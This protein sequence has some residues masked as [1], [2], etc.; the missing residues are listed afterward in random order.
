MLYVDGEGSTVGGVVGFGQGVFLGEGGV[1]VLEVEADGEGAAVESCDDVGFA[2]DPAGVVGGGAGECGVEELLV[3]LTEAADV[4]D[5]GMVSGDGEFAEGESEGP[6]GIEIEGG[7]AEE[8]FLVG[9]AGEI[10]GD[11]HAGL[12]PLASTM[13][14]GWQGWQGA[15]PAEIF[16]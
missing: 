16:A 12:G 10:V 4:D 13:R 9:D 3:G 5:D 2:L 11:G 14:R 1:V 15:Y 8:L 7:E 6:G